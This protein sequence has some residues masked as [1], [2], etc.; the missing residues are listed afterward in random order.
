M[1]LFADADLAG[2]INLIEML[3]DKNVFPAY[4]SDR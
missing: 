1:D 2:T 4:K 3:W